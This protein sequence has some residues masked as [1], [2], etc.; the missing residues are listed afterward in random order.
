MIKM[1]KMEVKGRNKEKT[2]NL[3]KNQPHLT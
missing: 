1:I 2:T 3:T